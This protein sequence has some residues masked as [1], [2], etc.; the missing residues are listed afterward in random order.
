MGKLGVLRHLKEHDRATAGELA[1]RIRVS[2]QATSLSTRELEELGLIERTRDDEDRRR[3]WFTLTDAGRARYEAEHRAAHAWLSSAIESR[4][5]AAEARKI[6][7]A[8]PTLLKLTEDDA[9][10]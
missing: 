8:I 9:D 4:L 2:P 6:A 5:T 1:A 10:D 7:A 3:I